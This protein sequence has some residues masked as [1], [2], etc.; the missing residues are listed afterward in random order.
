MAETRKD[1]AV[2][3]IPYNYRCELYNEDEGPPFD[4]Y[5]PGELRQTAARAEAERPLS[6]WWWIIGLIDMVVLMV[7]TFLTY[8]IWAGDFRWLDF[9][10]IGNAVFI[11]VTP[12]VCVA[13]IGVITCVHLGRPPTR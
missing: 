3:S 4:D 7:W 8:A 13:I 9:G 11:F 1:N 10:P 5:E 12:L 6:W 2:I